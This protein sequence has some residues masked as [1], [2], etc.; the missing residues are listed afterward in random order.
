M[1]DIE[2][3]ID[4]LIKSKNYDDL[5]AEERKIVEKEFGGEKAY[6]SYRKLVVL[7]SENKFAPGKEVKSKLDKSLR[8]ANPS[9]WQIAVDYKLPANA[10][11][12]AMIVL[13]C[14]SFWINKTETIIIEKPKIVQ[15]EPIIDTVFIDKLV[16]DTLIIENIR[17][18]EVP[19]YISVNK[20]PVIEKVE[21]LKG[22]NLTEQRA[23]LDILT[24]AP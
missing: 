12:P 22:S 16:T 8:L 20:E 23:L 7:A 2:K 24:S 9:W 14:L 11:V 3:Y 17:R 4:E 15:T 5:N 21:A 13:L 6:N 18:I 1:K 10:A 19:V